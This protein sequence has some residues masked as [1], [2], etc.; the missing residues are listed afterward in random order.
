MPPMLTTLL[1]LTSPLLA[2]IPGRGQTRV[3][4]TKQATVGHEGTFVVRIELPHSGRTWP[5][6]LTARVAAAL[7]ETGWRVGRLDESLHVTVSPLDCACASQSLSR[8]KFSLPRLPPWARGRR[9]GWNNARICSARDVRTHQRH[10]RRRPVQSRAR[11]M[12]GR[13]VHGVVPDI[14]SGRMR[15]V[16]RQG[17]DGSLLP[18]YLVM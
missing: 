1:V 7:C 3:I 9:R 15:G 16:R 2:A 10:G 6:C 17:P 5:Y 18:T 13:H 11:P 8:S 12:D 14:Q 4:A